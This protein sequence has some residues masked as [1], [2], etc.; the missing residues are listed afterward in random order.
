MSA[1]L[2]ALILVTDQERAPG[3]FEGPEFADFR[4]EHL[5]TRQRAIRRG[6]SFAEHRI[7]TSAC[8]PSRASMFTG[9]P[10]SVHGV[11]QT[12]GFGKRARDP[13]MCWLSPE[14]TPTLG[15]WARDADVEA[16]YL[17]KW[18]LS[19]TELDGS[20]GR[21]LVP[22][23]V[24]DAAYADADLLEPYGFSGWVGRPHGP[25]LAN[26]GI[27]RDHGYVE[28]AVRWLRARGDDRRRPPFVLVVSLVN[29]HDMV[30][31]PAWSLWRRRA[32]GLE[33]VPPLGA[34]PTDAVTPSREP[35]VLRAYRNH[36]PLAYGPRGVVRRLYARSAADYRRFY[37]SL[38]RRSDAHLAR[39]LGALRDAG[40]EDETQV[41]LT[42]DHGELLGAHGGLHQKWYCAFEEVLRVPFTT[43][44][45]RTRGREGT[46]DR[47]LSSHLDLLPTVLGCLGITHRSAL[48]GCDLLDPHA[49][50]IHETWFETRDH[51]LDGHDPVPA[52]TQRFPRLGRL[53][54]RLPP[55]PARRTARPSSRL[56]SLAS[57]TNS[58]PVP[59]DHG[60]AR[61]YKLIRYHD[62][63]RS[64]AP[65][66]LDA[67]P[68]GDD[69]WQLFDLDADPCERVDLTDSSAHAPIFRELHGR[70]RAR[71]MG[72]RVT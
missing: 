8:V 34:G 27:A 41:F 43:W 51:I 32:L 60:A 47:R 20:D 39:I 62:P 29:P 28:Q 38:L 31:W 15:R 64:R 3:D 42:A 53:A 49:P 61:T 18:H 24:A 12:D 45:P 4:R 33:G 35:E 71:S 72:S 55:M 16:A 54:A 44:G 46:H 25:L 14:G 67:R 52:F 65:R 10:P 48:P 26:A 5:P 68:G 59:G 6:V 7:V 58:L 1:P 40:L 69:E 36:Y 30:F 23:P 50:E 17:G 70:L 37:A 63:D 2:N 11:W 21:P 19:L 56:E 22:G 57:P 66:W 9:Q 13:A